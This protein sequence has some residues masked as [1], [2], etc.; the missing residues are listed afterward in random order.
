[1]VLSLLIQHA[2]LSALLPDEDKQHLMSSWVS[3]CTNGR[4]CPSMSRGV[5]YQLGKQKEQI[6]KA[7]C[8]SLFAVRRACFLQGPEQAPHR[9]QSQG[10]R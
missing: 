3:A 7:N 10:T 6:N 8:V 4:R 1:L 5:L 9:A 2:I